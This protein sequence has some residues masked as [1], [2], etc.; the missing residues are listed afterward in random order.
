[1]EDLTN[2]HAVG[3][4]YCDTFVKSELDYRED[5]SKA[6]SI[7]LKYFPFATTKN[8]NVDGNTSDISTLKQF[9]GSFSNASE[10]MCRT[11]A[12]G[13]HILSMFRCH[14]IEGPSATA[15]C[16]NGMDPLE[17]FPAVLNT[18]K[19]KSRNCNLV[20]QELQLDVKNTSTYRPA[21]VMTLKDFL[22]S[23]PNIGATR[24]NNSQSNDPCLKKIFPAFQARCVKLFNSGTNVWDIYLV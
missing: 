3:A 13:D 2:P 12:H 17:S 20:L 8:L 4:R 14:Y 1:M 22:K 16:W 10:L 5:P 18:D 11:T 19:M 21:V 6:Y 24:K 23:L 7:S 15:Q 9:S